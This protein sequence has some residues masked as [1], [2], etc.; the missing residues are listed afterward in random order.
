MPEI[1]P[2]LPLCQMGEKRRSGLLRTLR[3][4]N[5]NRPWPLFKRE[6]A[7]ARASG[8]GE[9]TESVEAKAC[10]VDSLRPSRL[11]GEELSV[12]GGLS[13]IFPHDRHGAPVGFQEE[14]GAFDFA[15]LVREIERK[16]LVWKDAQFRAAGDIH[17]P[18]ISSVHS[19]GLRQLIGG[20]ETDSG[21]AAGEFQRHHDL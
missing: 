12:E 17:P 16:H 13:E 6:Q 7:S 3:S 10:P 4:A 11:V 15:V 21:L 1:P 8:D 18:P 19:F 9:H 14:K 2:C 5:R 20:H